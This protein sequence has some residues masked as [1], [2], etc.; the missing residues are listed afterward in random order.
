MAA[1]V[2]IM[3]HGITLE[4]YPLTHQ[5][6]YDQIL[7]GLTKDTPALAGAFAQK[8]FVEWGHRPPDTATAELRPDQRIMDAENTLHNLAGFDA[9]RA[10]HNPL[11]HTIEPMEHP[12]ETVVDTAISV[13]TSPIKEVVAMYGFTDVFYYVSVD[14]EQAVRSTVYHQILSQI[15][16][17]RNQPQVCLHIYGHS[18]GITVAHDFLYGLFAPDHVPGYYIQAATPQDKDDYEYWRG[19]AQAGTLSLG[20]FSCTAS[21]LCLMTMRKQSM[22]D[23]LAA[24]Q[25]LDPSVIGV[26]ADKVHWRLFYAL[27]DV[28]G[29]PSRKVYGDS[30]GIEEFEV[31]NGFNPVTVHNDYG[32]NATVIS[33]MA[34]LI[35]SNLE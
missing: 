31:F 28:L 24:G 3:I 18:L 8:I 2:L 17:L 19:R 27:I 22:V 35:M 34:K 10:D 15:D 26:R 32:S 13:G 7:Q 6:D 14:G 12:I 21:Q 16:A 25:T 30:A 5:A 1:N 9:V 33:E 11:N 29:Y 20:S 23:M 4:T